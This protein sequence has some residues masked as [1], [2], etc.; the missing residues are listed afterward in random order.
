MSIT[1]IRKRQL[2]WEAIDSAFNR[3]EY[4]EE[5]TGE[6]ITDEER[7]YLQKA[8]SSMAKHVGITNHINII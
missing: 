4:W 6:D 7:D 3:M 5:L 1:N 2:K 8:I